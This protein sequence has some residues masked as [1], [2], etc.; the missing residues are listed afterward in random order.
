[1]R[2]AIPKPPIILHILPDFRLL[3]KKKSADGCYSAR[4]VHETIGLQNDTDK[5]KPSQQ[6]TVTDGAQPSCELHIQYVR[7]CEELDPRRAA[8]PGP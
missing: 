2:L 4:T 5:Q 8:W 3:K 6:S 1:M 7:K